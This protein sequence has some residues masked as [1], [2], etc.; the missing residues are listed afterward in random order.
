[1]SSYRRVGVATGALAAVPLLVTG[2]SSFERTLAGLVVFALLA[3]ALNVA[4]G[5]TDQLFLFTGALAG[6]GAYTASLSA[7]ALG[8]SAWL[9][10]PL[11][12]LVA[13]ATAGLVSWVAARREFTAVLVAILTL[14]LQLALT[15]LFVGASGLTGGS[16]GYPFEALGLAAAGDALGVS[17]T[18]VLYYLLVALLGLSLAGY[19]RLLDSRH[20][21]AFAAIRADETAARAAG[22]DVVRYRTAAGALA[23]ALVGVVGVGY[24]GLESYVAPSLFAFLRVDVLVLVVLVLGGLRSTLGPVV[25]AVVVVT[26]EELLRLLITGYDTVVFGALLIV[27]FL[28]FRQGIVPAAE[29]ALAR[30]RESG[31]AEEPA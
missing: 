9:T 14:N 22:I 1:V 5:A 31:D 3:T 7:A 23:G 6:V 28:Y 15:E 16:T 19:V 30:W 12:A 2:S 13:G 26:L 4:F 20:G 10:L 8:V 18:L 25:G 11:A 21:L 17:G 24:I 27:V 29:A